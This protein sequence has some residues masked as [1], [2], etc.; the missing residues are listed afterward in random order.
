MIIQANGEVGM[1]N[2][3]ENEVMPPLE[4]AKGVDGEE[5]AINGESLVVRQALNAHIKEDE[6]DH[7]R[8]SIFH[9]KCYVNNKVYNLII[10]GASCTNIVSTI[11]VEKLWIPT[12]KHYAPY[13][14]H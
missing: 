12:I 6:L 3:S 14:L 5:Y 7:Y 4:N 11:I 2:E 1:E 8:T 13:M 10:D 9:I